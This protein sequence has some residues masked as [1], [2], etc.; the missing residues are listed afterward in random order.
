MMTAS[1]TCRVLVLAMTATVFGGCGSKTATETPKG[2]EKSGEDDGEGGGGDEGE[3]GGGDGKFLVRY[4]EAADSDNGA[5]RDALMEVN[6]LEA[7]ATEFNKKINLPRDVTFVGKECGEEN[8]FFDSA[9]SEVQMCYEYMIFIQ[10]LVAESTIA[11]PEGMDD[12]QI[13][14]DAITAVLLHELGHALIYVLDLPITGKEEDVADQISAYYL[15]SNGL[16]T[17]VLNSAYV[18]ALIADGEDTSQL[19]WDTHSLSSQR[20]ANNVCW[21]FGADPDGQASWVDDGTIDADRAASCQG[22][23]EKMAQAIE[24]IMAPHLK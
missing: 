21:V 6:Y 19:F 4:D 22:E 20:Y 17:T 8:A 9:T 12:D 16:S 11:K 15:I 23:Y 24:A 2:A 5:W 13:V 10:R 7:I 1:H 14:N 3:G 18:W